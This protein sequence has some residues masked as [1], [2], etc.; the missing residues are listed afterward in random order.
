MGL[1]GFDPSVMKPTA[2][3]LNI[4]VALIATVQLGRAGLFRWHNFYPFGVLGFP[5]SLSPVFFLVL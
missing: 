2:L 1:A 4:V 5:F 3:A